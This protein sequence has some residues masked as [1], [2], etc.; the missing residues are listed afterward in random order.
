VAELEEELR[1]RMTE[2]RRLD[3][4]LRHLRADVVVKDEFIAVLNVEADKVQ[5]IRDL[6]GRVP[7]GSHIAQ[8]LEKQLRVGP[9]AR[10]ALAD[11]VRS[12]ASVGARRARS[13]AG[14]M[15]RRLMASSRPGS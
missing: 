1:L 6:L 4:E 14:R 9:D 2:V 12:T 7:F 3:L 15:K 8:G 11:R 10:P 13:R 5:K